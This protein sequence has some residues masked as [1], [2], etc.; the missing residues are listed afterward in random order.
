[1]LVQEEC[2][3]VNKMAQCPKNVFLTSGFLI[4]K[5]LG[6]SL[7]KYEDF[8]CWFIISFS[9]GPLISMFI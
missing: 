1:M 6:K 5:I 7:N 4:P 2:E 9:F 8:I 3:Q